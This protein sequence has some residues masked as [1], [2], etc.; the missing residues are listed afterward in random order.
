MRL[1]S[2]LS[3]RYCSPFSSHS[4]FLGFASLRFIKSRRDPC[5]CPTPINANHLIGFIATVQWCMSGS[6]L[7]HTA[8]SP[9][10]VTC[11]LVK[12]SV[13]LL[14]SHMTPP[15]PLLCTA[16]WVTPLPRACLQETCMHVQ[17]NST[18]NITV[19]TV[20][21]QLALLKFLLSSAAKWTKGKH[22]T[23]A[24]WH[25][26][27]RLFLIKSYMQIYVQVNTQIQWRVYPTLSTKQVSLV[28]RF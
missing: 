9:Y 21:H 10:R 12:L 25:L 2:R 24:W 1:F 22:S 8:P 17:A 6:S 13:L 27:S 7:P 20:I 19:S 16:P 11:V 4:P 14:P 23:K 18:R 5:I 3:S 15:P 28:L 26:W